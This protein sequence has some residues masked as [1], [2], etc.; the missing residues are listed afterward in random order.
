VRNVLIVVALVGLATIVAAFARRIRVPAPSLLVVAGLGVGLLPGVAPIQVTPEIVGLV[1]LPPL[2]FAA[3][4]EL[5]WPDLRRVWRPVTALAIGLVLVSALAVGFV[6]RVTVGLPPSAAFLLGAVLASTDPVAVTALGRRLSL[7]GRLQT[8]VQAES[9]FN[10]ATSL[11]LFRVATGFV[12][13]GGALAPGHV[14]LE[15]AWLAGG[16]T[17]VGALVAAIVAVLRRRTEDP[18]VETVTSLLTPYAAYVAAEAIGSSGVTAVVVAGVL[19][20]ILAPRLSNSDTRLQLTA[21]HATVVFV[22]ESIVFALIGLALPDLIL[23]LS[24]AHQRWLLPALAIAATLMLVRVAWMFP[25]AAFRQWRHVDEPRPMWQVP[26]VISWAGARGVVPLAAALSIPLADASGRPLPYRDLL[27]V[28]ATT[29]IVISLLVQGFTL[30]PLVRRAGLGVPAEHSRS[31]YGRARRQ[32]AE[33]GLDHLDELDARESVP[34]AVLDQ[35]RRGLRTWMDLSRD[36]GTDPASLRRT[37]RRVRREVIDVQGQRLARLSADG[38]ISEATR[39]RIRR[40]LDL[41]DARLRD[42]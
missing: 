25:L 18:M 12:V 23:E 16:G 26:A 1:V 13:A 11:I 4:E 29:V 3:G 8:L 10:D 30:A 27:I 19:L 42:D 17:A 31:E 20:G 2:L 22:L 14:A 38:H 40:E 24:G 33:A 34:R 5:S 7:P 6:A 35:V 9:L 41:E 37:Y 28:L 39:R 15:F 36:D 21:V 32:V